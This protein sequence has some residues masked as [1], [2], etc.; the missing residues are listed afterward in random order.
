MSEILNLPSDASLSSWADH[1]QD[2]IQ[3]VDGVLCELFCS[4][5]FALSARSDGSELMCKTRSKPTSG[6]LVKR[7]DG[8]STGENSF[9]LFHHMN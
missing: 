6:A 5:P 8:P 3:S 2:L 7:K 9:F 4:D 1:L